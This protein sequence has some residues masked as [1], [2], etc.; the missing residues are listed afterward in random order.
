V[1]PGSTPSLGSGSPDDRTRTVHIDAVAPEGV[2]GPYKLERE[3]GE[4]GMGIV[5]HAQQSQPIRRDVAL[6]VIKPGMD[7]RQVIARFESE[8]QA[9]AV[10]DHPNIARVFDAGATEKGLPYFVMEL[11][12][13][14]PITEYCDRKRLS[15]KERIELF[16]PVCQAIQHAHQK[17]VIHR[18]IKPSNILVAEQEGAPVAKVIDFGLAKALG[19]Q[20]SDATMMTNVGTVIGTLAYMSPEQAELTRQDIDT[21]S[22]VYSLG[23]VLYELLAGAAPLEPEKR[24]GTGYIEALQQIRESEPELPSTRLRHPSTATE[25]AARRRSEPARL[26]KLLHGELDWIAMRALEK[27]R[28]R[29]YSSASDL[30]SDLGRYLRNEPVLA[31]PPGAGYR[32][33]KFVRRHRAGVAAAA[34][35]AALLVA[36]L[37]TLSIQAR[38][39]ALERDRAN[40][41]AQASRRVADFLTELF[42]VSDPSEARGNTVT[43]R[44]ILDKGADRIV[45][46]LKNQPVIQARLMDTIGE[47]YKNLGLY[48]RAAPMFEDALAIRRR[49]LGNEHVEV[50]ESLDHLGVLVYLKGDLPGGEKLIR[51][52]LAMHR[53]LL[54]GESLEVA[55][56]LNDLGPI[57]RGEE[58]SAAVAEAERNYREALATRR[59]LLGNDHPAVA[60]SLNNL[61]LVLYFHKRDYAAAE[62]LFREALAMNERLLGESDQETAVTLNDLALILRDTAR[63]DEGEKLLRRAIAIDRKVLGEHHPTLGIVSNNLAFLLQRK[64][65]YQAAEAQ[66]RETL[67]IQRQNFPEDHWEIATVKSLLGSCLTA[68][69]RYRDAESML[70]A[71]YPVIR[72]NFGDSHNRTVVT[73]RRQCDLYTAWGQPEKAARYAAMLPQ[74]KRP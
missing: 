71:S 39:I 46:E 68:A 36:V 31:G 8:R 66:Y 5:Y 58:T 6:K 24:T 4:G 2:I 50:A 14:E 41:E 70:L 28:P 37:V 1:S 19:P 27:D 21:R 17:G 65:E 38:R 48:D 67:A 45:Q 33:R 15:V 44:E 56:E 60:Q 63:Y 35:L 40:Q 61:G 51:Q 54:G 72:S 29:R 16:I 11:V 18:D 9:L 25:V 23:A 22:D 62:P 55:Q 53:K 47:V 59:K 57:L 69:H 12:H 7:T 13:G 20:M 34:S 30:A 10:M 73:L 74:G 64:G 43:A 3:L 42:R 26:Y 52:A 49:A 32:A